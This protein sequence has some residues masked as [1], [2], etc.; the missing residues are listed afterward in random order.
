MNT[1]QAAGHPNSRYGL[2]CSA[3]RRAVD[4]SAPS[5]ACAYL[6]QRARALSETHTSG[7]DATRFAGAPSGL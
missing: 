1:M 2:R 7:M 3:L 5:S 4:P 6:H